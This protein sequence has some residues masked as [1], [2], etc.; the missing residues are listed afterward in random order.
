MRDVSFVIRPMAAGDAEGVAALSDQLGYPALPADISR[1]FWDIQGNPDSRVLVCEG[2][3]G[4]VLGWLH[5][6]GNHLLE[7]N[8]D[9]EVGGL[10]VADGARGRG[11]GT[12][13]MAAAETWARE[14]GYPVVSVRSNT[15]RTDAHEFYT[16]IGYTIVKS[17]YKF[18]KEI[19]SVGRPPQEES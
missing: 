14:R 5:V 16:R 18:R 1:R 17:Q 4:S 7:S 19:G 12:A 3:G 9:A 13:L 15:I 8:P 2:E 11:V 6:F 10:V